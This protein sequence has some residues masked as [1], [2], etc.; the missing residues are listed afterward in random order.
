MQFLFESCS[1]ISNGT[2][3]SLLFCEEYC[4]ALRRLK[5]SG[6]WIDDNVVLD[7]VQKE[8]SKMTEDGR[9]YYTA[10]TTLKKILKDM[11]RAN[12]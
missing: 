4:F 12:G 11:N 8:L 6:I 9:D 10:R 3:T 2:L 1:R 7:V 5:T